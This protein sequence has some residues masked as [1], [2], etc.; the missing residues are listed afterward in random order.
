MKTPSGEGVAVRG[1][2]WKRLMATNAPASVIF[3]RLLVG[4]VF[5]SEGL[6]KFLFSAELGPGRFEKIGFAHP[7]LA[8]GVAG[9]ELAC[10][11]LV[12][13]GLATRAA[14][15]P[16]IMVMLTAMVITKLPILLGHDLG[17]FHVRQL[18]RYGFWAMAHEARTDWAML[19]GSVYLLIVG[20]GRLSLDA[21]LAQSP[22]SR[23][24]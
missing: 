14:A 21:R 5:V 15:L 9:L 23:A 1:P 11:A 17:G 4:L 18:S 10:G 6:Q 22:P 13:L 3:V 12:V 8:Y 20:A 16:L 7:D 2:V 19:M 24:G